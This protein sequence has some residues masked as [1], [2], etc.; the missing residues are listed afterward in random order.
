MPS[1]LSA[2]DLLEVLRQNALLEASQLEELGRLAVPTSAQ[3]LG[4]GILQ[5][6]WLTPF[7][8]NRILQGRAQELFFGQYL[9]R[10]KLGEGGMGQVFEALDRTMHRAVALKLIHPAA[11]AN[12]EAV[13]RFLKEIRAAG[14]LDHPNI[15]RALHAGQIDTTHYLV[16][17]FA[18]GKDLHRLLQ[19]AQPLPVGRVCDWVRQAA[20]AL[21]H[22]AD[23]GMVHRD[24]KPSNLLLTTR[25]VVKLLDLG[26]ARPRPVQRQGGDATRAGLMMGTPDYIAPE[27]IAD[28][29]SVDIRADLYSLGCTLYHLLAGR[30]P[31]P[32][33]DGAAKLRCQLGA[34]PQ[35]VEQLR[36]GL[37]DGLAA[38]VRSLMRKRKDERPSLPRAVADTLAPFV[39]PSPLTEPILPS[40][41]P[42]ESV[43][44]L[45]ALV[46]TA[47]PLSPT[48]VQIQPT[49]L[50]PARRKRP[51]L[52]ALILAL[53]VG[54]IATWKLSGDRAGSDNP[55]GGGGGEQEVKT[56][57]PAGPAGKDTPRPGQKPVVLPPAKIPPWKGR[58]PWQPAELA[59]VLGD[60]RGRHWG[61][62]N[63]LAWSGDGKR[64]V[65]GG[66][67]GIRVW[68]AA[69]LREEF[70]FPEDNWHA[71]T[72][73]LSPDGK[74]LARGGYHRDVSYRDLATDG[75]RRAQPLGA[76]GRQQGKV[77]LLEFSAD[78]K[79]LLGV[80]EG[81]V[82]RWSLDRPERKAEVLRPAGP[83]PVALSAGLRLAHVRRDLTRSTL[84][85]DDLSGTSKERTVAEFLG[86]CHSL[87]L[88]RDA[89][90]L[91][92][93][94]GGEW[95]DIGRAASV[96]LWGLDREPPTE[97]GRYDRL[98]SGMG[99]PTFSA[100]GRRLAAASG[101]SILTWE[102]GDGKLGNPVER[103][104]HAALVSA[105]AFSPVSPTLASGSGDGTVRLWD[106]TLP[107]TD[108]ADKGAGLVPY[109]LAFAPDGK[110]LATVLRP[111][112][113]RT[114]LEMDSLVRLHTLGAAA[115]VRD[116][117]FHGFAQA[118]SFSP[119]GK[120]LAIWGNPGRGRR[121]DGEYAWSVLEVYNAATLKLVKTLGF[122]EE[123]LGAQFH[124]G[125]KF[126][127]LFTSSKYLPGD[128]RVIF[129]RFDTAGWKDQGE[130][131]VP[132][133]FGILA[134]GGRLGV[135]RQR[136]KKEVGVGTTDEAVVWDLD[137]LDRAPSERKRFTLGIWPFSGELLQAFSADGTRLAVVNGAGQVE[138][139]EPLTGRRL[140]GNKGSSRR[141]F[142]GKVSGL[143]F[144]ADGTQVATIE[145]EK[146]LALWQ[147][148]GAE[149]QV[150][151]TPWTFPGPVHAVAFDPSGQFLATANA[152]GSVY[153]LR[154]KPATP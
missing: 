98:K 97:R 36:A 94:S 53:A 20:L 3:A 83:G 59:L 82:L 47:P 77:E 25:G 7:Q 55:G 103:K 84:L 135:T 6:G 26:L 46:D 107:P 90:L 99:L 146:R 136:G 19:Q 92:A 115:E 81:E 129:R 151:G 100:D 119:D 41:A 140:G 134:S 45:A 111:A 35:P 14:A 42:S 68:E 121:V 128:A 141:G 37:P 125:G 138:L 63:L 62:I 9:L 79:S 85:V 58:L 126:C 101:T 132:G 130:L 116:V 12:P 54:G 120:L 30:V 2:A 105:L 93:V 16:M 109:A 32:V 145:D 117:A 118:V 142:L 147:L 39:Q 40:V 66:A 31:F 48:P 15:V 123:V 148:Q 70:F 49:P 154:L 86:V 57:G 78:G 106:P 10:R 64:L 150:Q 44:P 4:N 133:L 127:T 144:T 113:Q 131:R 88:S 17:E 91:A 11:L 51:L 34:E 52:I 122:R 110:H 95:K 60:E 76:R 8:M 137:R 152:N 72:L 21:Q 102:F 27:Q 75:G 80:I 43:P 23:C 73:A 13:D 112:R 114:S 89:R 18:E 71:T 143:A 74:R 29:G 87:A 69:T 38:V 96:R 108:Q 28:A 65:S 33:E 67:D 139:W 149:L 24:V 56:A 22:V 104:G 124:D 153:L 5:R 1:T 61:G 50:R